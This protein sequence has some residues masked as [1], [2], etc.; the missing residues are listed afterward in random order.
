MLDAQ[1]KEEA[2]LIGRWSSTTQ[3]EKTHVWKIEQ[4]M[5]Y[6]DD[7][8]AQ[9]PAAPHPSPPKHVLHIRLVL[10]LLMHIR[11]VLLSA[12]VSTSLHQVADFDCRGQMLCPTPAPPQT[13]HTS[14]RRV[15]SSNQ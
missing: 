10:L 8:S 4:Y 2:A 14:G 1:R 15:T 5:D 13:P 9:P 3:P 6:L 12:Q 7:D 11:L